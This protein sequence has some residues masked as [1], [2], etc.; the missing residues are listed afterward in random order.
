MKKLAIVFLLLVFALMIVSCGGNTADTNTETNANAETNGDAAANVNA[1][2][3]AAAN[4][5]TAAEDTTETEPSAGAPVQ[6]MIL[7]TIK[8]EIQEPFEE[9]VKTYNESQ[10]EYEV[11]IIPR[12]GD[13]VQMMTSLFASGNMPTIV[14]MGQE[15]SLFQESSCDVTDAEFSQLAFEGTKADVTVDGR[16][17][18]MPITIEAFGLLYNKAVL[19]EAIGGDFDPA[20]IDTRSALAELLA[21]VDALDSTEAAIHVSGLDWSLG[22]HFTNVMFTDQSADA[23]ARLAF[24]D[25]LRAGTADL[26]NNAVYNGWLETLDMLLAY[27][28]NAGSPLAP[29][30]DDGVLALADGEVGFWFMGNW[31]LPNLLEANPDVEYGILPVPISD[32]PDDYGNAQISIGVPSNLVIDCEQSTP[33]QQAGAIDFLNWFITDPV[34]QDYWVNQFNFLPVFEGITISPADAMSNQIIAYA[35]NGQS[36]QWMNNRYPAGGWQDM[37]ANMQKYVVGELDAAGLA[38]AIETYWAN[39]EE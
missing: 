20:T 13:P 25:S 16:V 32:N 27:N 35:A 1:E 23:A 37:G 4:A 8:P 38:G 21:Q 5:N 17:Y 26:A 6:I 2:T 19:D 7:G 34:G 24:I 31:A 28:Q 9:A 22:A 15:F 33:E 29:T 36:L 39:L 30:Y 11:V 12:D 3:D 10:D 14:N 18:G